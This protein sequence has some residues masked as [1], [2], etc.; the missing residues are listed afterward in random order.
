[1]KKT[2]VATLLLAALQISGCKSDKGDG[3]VGH[4]AGE[5]AAA[6]SSLDISKEDGVFHID[7]HYYNQ[8]M[9][10]DEVNRLEATPVSDTVLQISTALGNVNVR[11][12]DNAVWF[13]NRKYL[14]SK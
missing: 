8:F 11:M 1:M 14:K 5:G 10:R 4:W 3:F 13:E 9:T 12:E 2:V 6:K 7:H